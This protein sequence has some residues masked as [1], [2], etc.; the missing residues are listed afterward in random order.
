MCD[1]CNLTFNM[2]KL[3]KSLVKLHV[4][5]LND[6]LLEYLSANSKISEKSEVLSKRQRKTY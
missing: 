4:I 1:F 5:I 3:L 6:I 2:T